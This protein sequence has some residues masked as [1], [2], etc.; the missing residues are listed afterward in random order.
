MQMIRF[1][2]LVRVSTEKQEKRGESLNTQ[3]TQIIDTVKTLGVIPEHCW[4]KGQEH[5]TADFERKIL[6]KLLEDS[7]K[8]LF[9]AVVVVDPSR[10]SRDNRKSKEGL[11]ILRQNGIRFF[12]GST[13]FDLFDPTQN[14]FLGMSA[15]INEFEAKLRNKKSIESRIHR[16]KRGIPC[17]GKLPFGRTWSEKEGWGVDDEKKRTIEQA[18]ARYLAGESVMDIALSIG[19]NASGLYRILKDRSSTK[20][21]IHFKKPDLK[22][23]EP[24]EFTIPHLLEE[25]TI[26]AIRERGQANKTYNHGELKNRYLLSRMI[27]CPTC[28]RALTGSVNHSGKKY[29]AHSKSKALTRCSEYKHIPADIIEPAVLLLLARS[30]GDKDLVKKAIEAAAPDL[31]R[32][33]T[34]RKEQT[35]NE[36]RLKELGQQLNRL[37]EKAAKGILSDGDISGYRQRIEESEKAIHER[38]AVIAGEIAAIPGADKIKKLGMFTGKIAR[39]HSKDNPKW[40]LKK[41]Y[42]YQKELLRS[43]FAGKDPQGHRYG[44]WIKYNEKTKKF[45]FEIRGILGSELMATP[46]DTWTIAELFKLDPDY[47]DVEAEAEKILEGITKSTMH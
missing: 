8:D 32:V 17:A 34:L 14:L 11:E 33:E 3:T 39:G 41:S 43:A 47:Q 30:F 27:F 10:W 26:H 28:G 31:D 6:D 36:N 40:I 9:D 18:A 4:Y 20:W 19:M 46:L 25:E 29:Y 44:V 22:I 13:E 15:E 37:V 24:V 12:V 38:Q 2:A 23:D 35:D 7:G 42:E 21:E 16:A 45:D 1:A 5:G